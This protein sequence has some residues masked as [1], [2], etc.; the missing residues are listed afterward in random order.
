MG[1]RNQRRWAGPG[2][3][4]SDFL[5]WAD[6]SD[7]DRRRVDRARLKSATRVVSKPMRARHA[8]ALALVVWYLVIPPPSSPRQLNYGNAWSDPS[9]VVKGPFQDS[10]SCNGEKLSL[11]KRRLK[12]APDFE[13]SL[14]Y[15][16]LTSAQC[17]SQEQ[18]ESWRKR[19]RKGEAK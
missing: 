13:L 2:N 11:L 9:C 16:S 15:F 6:R 17:L 5:L 14:A 3:V 18:Y 12:D 8:A 4:R 19:L 1:W 7:L 10:E